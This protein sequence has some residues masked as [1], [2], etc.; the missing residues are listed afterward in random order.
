MTPVTIHLPD[1]IAAQYQP[2]ELPR[3][4]LEDFAVQEYAR[5]R[6]TL[7]QLRQ[8]L[9]LPNRFDAHALLH[10]HGV[11][12]Y[13]YEDDHKDVGTLDHLRP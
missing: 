1:A 3:C 8:L 2:D 6:L 9:G 4:V 5:G 7:L 12:F 11:S 13:T 10:Q